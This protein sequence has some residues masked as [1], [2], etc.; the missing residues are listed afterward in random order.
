MLELPKGTLVSNVINHSFEKTN[1]PMQDAYFSVC[2]KKLL[3]FHK[4][5]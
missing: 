5:Q 3:I 4:L 2:R 1:R